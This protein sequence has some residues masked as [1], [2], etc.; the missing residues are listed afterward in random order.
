MIR[1]KEVA[2]QTAT[3]M[4]LQGFDLIKHLTELQGI[5]GNE[6]TGVRRF[7]Q[8]ELTLESEVWD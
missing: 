1:A 6:R 7:L 8:E 2:V 5:S 4:T 3:G